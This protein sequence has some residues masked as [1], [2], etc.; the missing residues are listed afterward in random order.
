MVSYVLSAKDRCS[1][2]IPDSKRSSLSLLAR[3]LRLRLAAGDDSVSMHAIATFQALR[4]Y[5]RPR[6][7]GLLGG[8]SL[9]F[10]DDDMDHVNSISERTVTLSVAEGLR[11]LL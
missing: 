7:S 2:K 4:D 5:L 6:V 1:S 3:Q 8:D 10:S 11:R 9:E